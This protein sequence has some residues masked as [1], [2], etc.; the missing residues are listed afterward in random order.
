[1]TETPPP[2]TEEVFKRV[3]GYA[4]IDLE[5]YTRI[6][7]PARCRSFRSALALDT[8]QK[9]DLLAQARETNDRGLVAD[10]LQFFK[11]LRAADHT[12]FLAGPGANI[13]IEWNT[14]NEE[15]TNTMIEDYLEPQ[16]IKSEETERIKMETI[17]ASIQA[18]LTE[19]VAPGTTEGMTSNLNQSG[20]STKID[21]AS[22]DYGFAKKSLKAF[23]DIKF[24]TVPVKTKEL[25]SLKIAVKN[26][27]RSM[28]ME[29]LLDKDY[30]VPEEGTDAHN[31]YVV[32][33][34]FFFS[35]IVQM[36]TDPDHEARM[37]L[38]TD[39][40]D[41]DG[42]GAWLKLMGHYDD[43]TIEES[44]VETL[45]N[46][47][48]NLRLNKVH[49]GANKTYVTNYAAHMA[50]MKEEGSPVDPNAA[51]DIF[52]S[53]IDHSSYDY[54]VMDCRLNKY[55]LTECY[56]RIGKVGVSIEKTAN[57]SNR[58]LNSATTPG[59]TGGGNGGNGQHGNGGGKL[60]F[61]NREVLKTGRF[62]NY[63]DYKSLSQADRKKFFRQKDKW[64]EEGKLD[65]PSG[66]GDF[67]KRIIKEVYTE[68]IEGIKGI[69]APSQ[70]AP[71]AQSTS[72]GDDY[73]E[74]VLKALQPKC[75]V[76]HITM[77]QVNVTLQQ[78]TSN[79]I[80]DIGAD[81]GLFGDAFYMLNHSERSVN[82]SGFDEAMVKEDLK[83]GTGVAAYDCS[84]GT[85]ILVVVNEA[86][87]HTS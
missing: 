40:V 47:W 42:H 38:L 21:L 2:S 85:T 55:S 58:K 11:L 48:M 32:D 51:R 33:N 83:I 34:K 13:N 35:V 69:P 30:V 67:K 22:N 77:S 45:Y 53:H 61:Q 46:K 54:I 41:N 87:D 62:K 37:W 52:L 43:E 9:A 14:F 86:I 68:L 36:V 26:I 81:T 50:A 39:D 74:R 8:D 84:D 17:N 10:S 23:S 71:P 70:D 56:E 49:Y 59:N 72:T 75:K 60:I 82:V 64:R 20:V 27:M 3:L 6:L 57:K 16:R 15:M 44:L 66:N 4:N 5:F 65:E 29:H 7:D 76:A 18:S 79:A 80:C 78:T 1:M 28:N 31:K 73:K 25:K 24:P 63:E 12:R 19:I